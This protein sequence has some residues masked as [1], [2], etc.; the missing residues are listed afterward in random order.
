MDETPSA[1][2]SVPSE[3]APSPRPALSSTPGCSYLPQT[4]P[5]AG[6]RRQPKHPQPQARAESPDTAA[7]TE[8]RE[9]RGQPEV[10]HSEEA[11]AALWAQG[12]EWLRGCVFL[13][14]A[15]PDLE[16]SAVDPPMS[17]APQPPGPGQTTQNRTSGKLRGGGPRMG[18]RGRT[19]AS[20]PT[21][22]PEHTG[23]TPSCCSTTRGP[24]GLRWEHKAFCGALL[25]MWTAPSLQTGLRDPPP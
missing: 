8:H 23:G 3:S 15:W 9:G 11:W 21:L 19:P 22:Q 10:A 5:A 17:R 24:P 1:R 20:P 13:L 14:C 2:A 12:R 6:P 18:L 4:A 16:A 25:H 7:N